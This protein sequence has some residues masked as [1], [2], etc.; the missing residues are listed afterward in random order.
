[1][2]FAIIVGGCHSV[3]SLRCEDCTFCMINKSRIPMISVQNGESLSNAIESAINALDTKGAR[4]DFI[5][6]LPEDGSEPKVEGFSAT[7]IALK[8]VMRLLCDSC[9]YCYVINSG[10]TLCFIPK[11]AETFFPIPCDRESN[12]NST[13]DSNNR[14]DHTN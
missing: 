13:V 7:D 14:Q 2:I 10:G 11:Y 8:D 1:M 4:V 5:T 12:L 9:S 3:D 6:Q